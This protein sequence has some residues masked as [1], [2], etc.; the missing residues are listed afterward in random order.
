MMVR[1]IG[2]KVPFDGG[3][4]VRKMLSA[5]Q[6][7]SEA[8]GG[9]GR[10]SPATRSQQRLHRYLKLQKLGPSNLVR[11]LRSHSLPSISFLPPQPAEVWAR[12]RM[13]AVLP[14]SADVHLGKNIDNQ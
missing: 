13:R 2:R 3:L 14:L 5:R 12:H 4:L 8:A 9:G 10:H 7:Q 6:R 1:W 11:P